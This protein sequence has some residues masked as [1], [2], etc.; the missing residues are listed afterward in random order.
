MSVPSYGK[1]LGWGKPM[2]GEVLNGFVQVQEK[3]DGSQF[4]F[5]RDAYDGLHFASHHCDLFPGAAGMFQKAV[6]YVSAMPAE[7]FETGIV[8]CCEYLGKPKQNT[9]SYG[10]APTNNLVLFD[11]YDTL[12]Q[13]FISRVYL[14]H[15]ADRL[16]ID[17]I[18]LL[19]ASDEA[20]EDF[21][22]SWLDT[23][24]YLGGEKVEG[25]VVK[26]YDQ[27][28][29]IGGQV[30]PLFVKLV[31]NA[32]RERNDKAWNADS[33]KSKVA[34]LVDSYCTAARWEK[35][36]Q[37]MSERGDLTGTVKD[38]GPLLGEIAHDLT[39]EETED[40]KERL[41]RIYKGDIVRAAQRGFPDWYK[42]HLA[43]ADEL[44][45]AEAING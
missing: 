22:R 37:H 23:E 27:H 12:R 15:Y 1:V 38:I 43:M 29:V 19:C 5:M 40:A 34:T 31:N 33:G 39:D 30:M 11:A 8:Y 24:S 42:A 10:R 26:N 21:V 44:D 25:V 2:T 6:D 36:V 41:W 3:V 13:R 35:A 17:L 45:A 18:P 7:A 28:V 20:G 14:M 16:G 32:F 4:R 9:L